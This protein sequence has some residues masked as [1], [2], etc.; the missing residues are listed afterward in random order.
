M[1]DFGLHH[2]PSNTTRNL[3][4]CVIPMKIDHFFSF[5]F[6]FLNLVLGY[7]DLSIYLKVIFLVPMP[8]RHGIR[9]NRA[10]I[11]LFCNKRKAMI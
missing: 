9:Y 5:S 3:K 7:S 4:A 6:F 1:G 10:I 2:H 11:A 8:S